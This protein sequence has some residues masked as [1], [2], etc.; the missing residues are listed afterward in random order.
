MED[1]GLRL[2]RLEEDTGP[3]RLNKNPVELVSECVML[4]GGQGWDDD[5]CV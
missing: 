1:E 5:D 4:E 2:L 3:F